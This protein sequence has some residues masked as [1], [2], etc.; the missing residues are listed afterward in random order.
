MA[1]K[2]VQTIAAA[3]RPTA[4]G[5]GRKKNRR[6]D[7][8]RGGSSSSSA[9][10]RKP[11]MEKEEPTDSEDINE[12]KTP[13]KVTPSLVNMSSSDKLH[14]LSRSEFDAGCA[15]PLSSAT[16]HVRQEQNNEI[17]DA[18]DN[19]YIRAIPRHYITIDLR[20]VD[21]VVALLF[22][23]AI[24]RTEA[25]QQLIRSIRRALAEIIVKCD[26]QCTKGLAADA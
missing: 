6:D 23:S 18:V 25:M 3:V 5:R 15:L 1:D 24:A 2:A 10:A 17:N 7:S 22:S 11:M 19:A 20:K 26:D 8:S 9:P 14:S 16:A 21:R 4:N 13:R 12:L